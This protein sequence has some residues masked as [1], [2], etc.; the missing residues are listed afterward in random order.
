MAT[1]GIWAQ[2]KE[3][4]GALWDTDSPLPWAWELSIRTFALCPGVLNTGWPRSEI[5][6][7]GYWIIANTLPRAEFFFW[8]QNELFGWN[9]W[10]MGNGSIVH[11]ATS[12]WE[13]CYQDRNF[14]FCIGGLKFL[15]ETHIFWLRN[16]KARVTADMYTNKK[17][18]FFSVTIQFINSPGNKFCPICI[19][20][21]SIQ[22]NCSYIINHLNLVTWPCGWVN[23]TLCRSSFLWNEG[24]N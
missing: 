15:A 24:Q 4:W 20:S 21:L 2:K 18:M 8:H 11:N 7:I 16:S 17:K 12:H 14:L 3:M 10:G 22:Q 6:I 5:S 13:I 9:T 19:I 23:H 1:S